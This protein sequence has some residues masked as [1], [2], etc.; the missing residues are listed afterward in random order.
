MKPLDPFT[1][2]PKQCIKELDQ[3]DALLK[4]KSEL[5][6]RMDI[7]PFFKANPHLAAYTG[8]YAPS[9]V[10]F[11]RLN[12]E[13]TFYGDFRADLLVGDWNRKSYCLIE[14]EDAKADSIFKKGSRT[15]KDWSPRFE[16]G[17]SQ[18]VDWLWKI[19]DMKQSTQGRTM[20]G[21]DT[22]DFMGMLIIGRDKFLDDKDTDKARLKWRL[23]KVVVNSQK[24][25]CITFD[26]LAID[27]RTSLKIYGIT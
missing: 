20:F 12:T 25:A 22:Y 17:Y 21:A 7:L 5:D 9:M 3:F 14:F 10:E 19:D 27:L 16:H 1:F 26:Q 8:S 2:D 24:I 15:T 18:L 6:E 4:S 13:Y 23:D 11:D